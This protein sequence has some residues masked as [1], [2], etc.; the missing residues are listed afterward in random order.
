MQSEREAPQLYCKQVARGRETRVQLHGPRRRWIPP[1]RD[2]AEFSIVDGHQL[3]R[4]G[5]SRQPRACVCASRSAPLHEVVLAVVVVACCEAADDCGGHP[6]RD[7]W[8]NS[9][10]HWESPIHTL[11]IG[12]VCKRT[13]CSREMAMRKQ[14]VCACATSISARA[15]R[16]RTMLRR[17]RDAWRG[18]E[19]P[20]SW[21]YRFSL[22][23]K[24]QNLQVSRTAGF[25]KS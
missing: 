5:E 24:S 6:V 18:I 19:I 16:R 3:A 21:I 10:E 13:E 25:I 1:R 12:I 22:F 11:R 17:N 15:F 4:A 7:R 2:M 20:S 14:Y 8:T 23:S 9:T